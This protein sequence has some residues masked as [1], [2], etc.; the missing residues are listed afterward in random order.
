MIYYGANKFQQ[1]SVTQ[2]GYFHKR[3]DKSEILG[4]VWK[5]VFHIEYSLWS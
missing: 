1:V 3:T 5:N 4:H 2:I